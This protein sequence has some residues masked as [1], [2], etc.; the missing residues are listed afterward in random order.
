MKDVRVAT[1]MPGLW[2]VCIGGEK[3]GGNRAEGPGKAGVSMAHKL[4]WLRCWVI[5]RALGRRRISGDR[6]WLQRIWQRGKTCREEPNLCIAVWK[7]SSWI[8]QIRAILKPGVW[9]ANLEEESIGQN[10]PWVQLN[11]PGC[12]GS[13]RFQGASQAGTQRQGEVSWYRDPVQSLNQQHQWR[14]QISVKLNLRKVTTL[15]HAHHS[16]WPQSR[17]RTHN[18]YPPPRSSFQSTTPQVPCSLQLASFLFEFVWS[19]MNGK[20]CDQVV[21]PASKSWRGG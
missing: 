7:M 12:T 19:P 1:V 6:L 17:T 14:L 20:D 21:I 16:R 15:F 18:A 9:E 2:G 8:Q 10:R 5:V 13:I 4:M 11:Q 3:G